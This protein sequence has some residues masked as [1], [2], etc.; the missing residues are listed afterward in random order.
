[1]QSQRTKDGRVITNYNRERMVNPYG[2]PIIP[3]GA[4][5][6]RTFYKKSLINSR[7]KKLGKHQFMYGYRS[8]K[9]ENMVKLLT[10]T[11]DGRYYK[12]YQP[13]NFL[14]KLNPP[15]PVNA[16]S[17]NSQLSQED[18]RDFYYRQ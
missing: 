13:F 1:M 9:Q 11:S 16:P 14:L 3:F 17:W 12:A 4:Y 10:R 15:F 2:R 6:P 7:M 8:K 5:N 18:N